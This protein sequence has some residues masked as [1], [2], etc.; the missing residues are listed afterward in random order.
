MEKVTLTEIHV[1]RIYS[2]GTSTTFQRR[3]SPQVPNKE[4]PEVLAETP[5]AKITKWEKH[6]QILLRVKRRNNRRLTI[7]D[8]AVK[9][10]SNLI[11]QLDEKRL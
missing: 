8:E 11:Y 6:Y 3:I 7:F 2:D 4:F 1:T 5:H 10:L 9:N